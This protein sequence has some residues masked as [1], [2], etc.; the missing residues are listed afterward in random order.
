MCGS[1]KQRAG[2]VSTMRSRL[3]LRGQYLAL[4]L[5]AARARAPRAEELRAVL[6]A[7]TPV[8][9]VLYT[10]ALLAW[11]QRLGWIWSGTDLGAERQPCPGVVGTG[12]E[13]GGSEVAQTGD[14][15]DRAAVLFCWASRAAHPAAEVEAE[16]ELELVRSSGEIVRSSGEIGRRSGLGR[17]RRGE[18]E[19]AVRAVPGVAS[20]CALDAQ[21][22]R[23]AGL[24]SCVG[25]QPR[26]GAGKGRREWCTSSDGRGGSQPPPPSMAGSA[27]RS[28]TARWRRRRWRRRR[29][30]RRQ[31]WRRW[32]R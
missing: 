10:C 20:D 28:A 9:H 27:T 24:E 14:A 30:R 1:Y 3:R 7:A 8:V 17:H 12:A 23:V 5:G 25:L 21:G 32:R 19:T 11:G 6:D 31:R 22:C 16:A 18:G 13:G 26:R 4:Q 29:R 2:P 15:S